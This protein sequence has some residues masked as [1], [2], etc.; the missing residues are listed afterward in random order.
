MQTKT[1]AHGSGATNP[2]PGL[3]ESS[4]E[5]QPPLVR[6]SPSQVQNFPIQPVPRSCAAR[7]RRGLGNAE[8]RT[9]L[10]FLRLTS[11]PL[12]DDRSL[13]FRPSNNYR[14]GAPPQL[15]GKSVTVAWTED[16][17]FRFVG[18]KDFTT[19]AFPKSVSIYVSSQGRTF[20]RLTA[21]GP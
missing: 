1:P 6:E 3:S 19:R 10:A 2:R 13:A 18:D 12:A 15:R 5:T 20:A 7:C 16:R 21:R 17:V 14:V 9:A 11:F 4:F 8:L